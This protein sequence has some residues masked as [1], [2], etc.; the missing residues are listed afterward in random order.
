MVLAMTSAT[1]GGDGRELEAQIAAIEQ[2]GV[3]LLAVRGD[4]LVHDSAV[5]AHELVLHP[6]AQAGPVL[7]GDT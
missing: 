1:S 4:E 6:L 3:I 5:G 7:G 2:Q